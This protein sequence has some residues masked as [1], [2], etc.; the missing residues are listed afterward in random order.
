MA[1]IQ[2]LGY[3]GG[4]SGLAK[5]LAP[6]RAPAVGDTEQV[7]ED[8]TPIE[9]DVSNRT[10]PVRHVSPHTAAALLGQPRARLTERQ[11]HTVDVLKGRCPGFTR[12][13]A[14]S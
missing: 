11:A 2:A 8:P 7:I 14:W 12:C 4:Y 5:L 3:V 13:G 1:E 10:V 6:W 9:H